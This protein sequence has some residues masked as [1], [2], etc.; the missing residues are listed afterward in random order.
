MRVPTILALPASAQMAWTRIARARHSARP[1]MTDAEKSRY[2]HG[3]VLGGWS[4]ER[5][6]WPAFADHDG[7]NGSAAIAALISLQSLG[8]NRLG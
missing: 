8:E 6:G 3:L 1:A 2:Q 4:G 5:R 7:M